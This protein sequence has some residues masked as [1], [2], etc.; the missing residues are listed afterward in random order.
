MAYL[1]VDEM[2]EEHPDLMHDKY[3]DE[4]FPKELPQGP[5]EARNRGF[6]GS[7][8]VMEVMLGTTHFWVLMERH[9]FG[10]K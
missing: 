6:K 1:I 4:V 5:G 8:S 2:H 9:Y 10:N 3:W 7:T